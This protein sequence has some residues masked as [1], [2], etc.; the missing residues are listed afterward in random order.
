M[1]GGCPDNR[2]ERGGFP[3]LERVRRL[4]IVVSVDKYGRKGR[5][6]DFFPV[7]NRVAFPA[8]SI[9]RMVCRADLHPVTPCVPQGAGDE[10]RAAEDILLVAGVGGDG[11]NPKEFQQFVQEALLVLPEIGVQFFH[12]AA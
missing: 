4:Y 12:R 11:G 8:D 1:D 2:F 9:L 5:V 6:D 10:F 7:D 3:K